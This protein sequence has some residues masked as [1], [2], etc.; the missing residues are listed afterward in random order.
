MPSL[1]ARITP[2]PSR[3]HRTQTSR[4]LAPSLH[5][6]S[7]VASSSSSRLPESG[8]T[9]DFGA[10]WHDALDDFKELTGEDIRD[11]SSLL[12]RRLRECLDYTGVVGALEEEAQAFR[13][14]RQGSPNAIKMRSVLRP[15]VRAV[16]SVTDL[17][18][19]VASMTVR[20]YLAIPIMQFI[21]K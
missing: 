21:I 10:L 15:F 3:G 18:A 19:D 16:L 4:P 2:R 13:A 11:E 5:V 12:H 17:G 6:G 7:S 8:A 14:Y 9:D 1:L 20:V